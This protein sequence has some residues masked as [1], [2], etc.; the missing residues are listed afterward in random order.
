MGPI[1]GKSESY[2]IHKLTNPA[3]SKSQD[4]ASGAGI[5]LSRR[6]QPELHEEWQQEQQPESVESKDAALLPEFLIPD[7]AVLK[8][9]HKVGNIQTQQLGGVITS[10]SHAD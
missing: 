1:A 5:K 6:A 4:A 9:L 2:S 10:I 7:N 8:P 3:H